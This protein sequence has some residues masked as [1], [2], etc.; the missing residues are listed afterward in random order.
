MSANP[1]APTPPAALI[2]GSTTSSTTLGTRSATARTLSL[3]RLAARF[4]VRLVAP[5]VVEHLVQWNLGARDMFHGALDHISALSADFAARIAP[6]PDSS[7]LTTDPLAAMATNQSSGF[8][9]RDDPNHHYTRYHAGTDFLLSSPARRLLAAG[10]GAAPATFCGRQGGYGNVIYVD[11]GGG[12][13][14]RYA[15]LSRIEVQKDATLTAGQEIGK[16][17]STGRAT[18]PHLP[19]RGAHRRPRGQPDPG[20]AG[21]RS[22]AHGAGVG[23]H[24]GVRALARA[25][26]ARAPPA[27]TTRATRRPRR[28]RRP[29]PP[30]SARIAP[31]T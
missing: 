21:R 18:G 1:S 3:A 31:V 14:T 25:R 22:P 20:D 10:D 29:S 16:V 17:G 11:H 24:R 12:V 19:L 4:D 28:R 15:H 7:I 30:S 23:A 27:S 13:T 2:S 9:W 26:G 8:G 6:P 5:E